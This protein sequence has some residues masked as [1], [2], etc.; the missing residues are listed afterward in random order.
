[1]NIPDYKKWA[2]PCALPECNEQVGYHKRYKKAN[3][4]YGYKWK[5]FCDYHR[6]V[7]G[8]EA[9]KAFKH[10][11]DGCENRNGIYG[12]VCT[13]QN[14]DAEYLE[15]DHFD[16]DRFNNDQENL[17]RVCSNCHKRKTKERGEYQN[18]YITRNTHFDNLF[19]WEKR[20]PL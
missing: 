7:V 18:R 11:A 5:T 3:G 14:V 4:E 8:K 6:S 10:A 15:I 13:S 9:V 19:E 1:M 2:P 16:G 12:F 17:V 20:N